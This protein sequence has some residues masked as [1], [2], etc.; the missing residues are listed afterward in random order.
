MQKKTNLII[1]VCLAFSIILSGCSSS[2]KKTIDL[3]EYVN[4]SF[5]DVN[6]EGRASY[7]FDYDGFEESLALALREDID[8][9]QFLRDST[10]IGDSINIS[11]DK[12]TNLSN[13]DA[14]VLTLTYDSAVAKKY[15][16]KLISGTK[17][18]A[19]DGLE[20]IDEFIATQDDII[21]AVADETVFYWNQNIPIVPEMISDF[22]ITDS[23]A[24]NKRKTAE[25]K[26]TCDIDCKIVVLSINGSVSYKYSDG[27]WTI[28][29]V[30]RTAQ[31]KSYTLSGTYEGTEWGI[32]GYGVSCNA[33]YIISENSDGSYEAEATWSGNQESL[34]MEEITAKVSFTN[35]LDNARLIA[36]SDDAL[37]DAIGRNPYGYGRA[38]RLD[39]YNGGFT[40]K[41]EVELQKVDELSSDNQ[42]ELV[43]EVEESGL[44]VE[45]AGVLGK[46]R[47]EII[48]TLGTPSRETSSTDSPMDSI[49][50]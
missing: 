1:A 22:E 18:Y 6:K 30:T 34:D 2:G 42:N 4:V 50:Y 39:F 25:V 15:G 40:S 36:F 13:G 24:N 12:S 26:Y 28:S 44:P 3:M 7:S 32:A 16:L 14:V 5:A 43:K 9:L 21:N 38:F 49:V 17:T 45:V 11:L 41:G 46:T 35:F 20:V 31:L 47:A 23:Q 10:I 27:E 29:Q 33:K 37:I 8:S 19:V 48:E